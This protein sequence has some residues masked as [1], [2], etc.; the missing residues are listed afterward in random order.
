MNISIAFKNDKYCIMIERYAQ[1]PSYTNGRI[2][3]DVPDNRNVRFMYLLKKAL[4]Q[5]KGLGNDIE[6]VVTI[7]GSNSHVLQW[8][9][10]GASI[11]EYETEF[12]DLYSLLCTIPCQFS[13]VHN[14][15]PKAKS[16][17]EDEQS[18]NIVGSD[19]LLSMM[20]D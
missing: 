1:V 6:D 15:N 7:E 2:L 5:L 11:K 13:F 16:H 20:E 17:L 4:L 8:L 10:N 12:E 19:A 18:V 3:S 14:K 9:V